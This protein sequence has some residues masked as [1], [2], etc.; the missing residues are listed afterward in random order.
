M[1]NIILYGAPAAGKGTQCELLIERYGYNHISTG[2]LFR[3]LDDSTELGKTIKET[4]AKGNLVDNE[5]T[6]QL[7]KSKLDTL[8]GL[9]V[10][11]GFPRNLEQ[12]KMLDEYFRDYVVINLDVEYEEAMKR[13]LGRLNCPKCGEGYNKFNP[14]MLPKNSNLCDNCN[15]ELMS[16]DDDNEESFKK[17]FEIYTNNLEDVLDYY[18]NK[19][20]LY[21]VKSV[22]PE[23][24]FKNL[25]GVINNGNY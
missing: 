12:A 8:N 9:V 21:I 15:V 22:N 5:T 16:R 1:K 20:L 24:T 25:E 23:E 19:N 18:R 11:D 10:L 13:A 4:I 2:D 17:R 3:N 14:D 7:V 6:S